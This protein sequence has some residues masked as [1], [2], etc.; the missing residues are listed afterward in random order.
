[1]RSF[2]VRELRCWQVDEL[3]VVC[4]LSVFVVRSLFVRCSLCRSFS[5]LEYDCCC[6]REFSAAAAAAAAAVVV[7]VQ[8]YKSNAVV[9]VVV[10]ACAAATALAAL[11]GGV[12]DWRNDNAATG[13][14]V[15][16]YCRM[17]CCYRPIGVCVF[18]MLF[19]LQLRLRR[20]TQRIHHTMRG[21]GSSSG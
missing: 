8:S 16:S 14:T 10:V 2:V 5:T 17:S 3:V 20:Q 21:L 13:D 4:R 11:G 6:C 18:S 12:V 15:D 1:M 7:V 19:E 9:A